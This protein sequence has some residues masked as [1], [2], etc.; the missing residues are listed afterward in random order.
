[1]SENRAKSPKNHHYI[2]HESS[3]QPLCCNDTRTITGF[4][5]SSA[6]SIGRS[7]F[8][9]QVKHS[10]VSVAHLKKFVPKKTAGFSSLHHRRKLFSTAFRGVIRARPFGAMYLS[11]Y[12]PSRPHHIEKSID[13]GWEP[14]HHAAANNQVAVIRELLRLGASAHAKTGVR[15]T[16]FGDQYI[17]RTAL[18]AAHCCWP[19]VWL[20]PTPLCREQR[21]HIGCPGTD[22]GEGPCLRCRHADSPKL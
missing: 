18:A 20:H 3:S 7:S 2:A 21:T 5:T 9:P 6:C 10:I 4:S 8:V 11:S 1:M 17:A 13:G 22:H 12:S 16:L 15:V 19:A 14:I